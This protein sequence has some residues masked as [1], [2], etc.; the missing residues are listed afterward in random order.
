[1]WFLGFLPYLS[2]NLNFVVL[3]NSKTLYWFFDKA[4]TGFFGFCHIEPGLWNQLNIQPGKM[5]VEQCGKFPQFSGVTAGEYYFV[6][7]S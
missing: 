7:S 1:M 3:S 2:Q 4:E 6:H 5:G